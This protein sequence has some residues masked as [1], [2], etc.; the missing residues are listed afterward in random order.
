MAIPL[1]AATG[2]DAVVLTCVVASGP[3]CPAN[4]HTP[5]PTTALPMS[6]INKGRCQEFLD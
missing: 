2:S 1:V 6:A 3:E 5:V 4:H